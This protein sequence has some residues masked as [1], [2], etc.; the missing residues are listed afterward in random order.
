MKTSR[1]LIGCIIGIAL[2]AR[3]W[4]LDKYPAKGE[5]LDEYFWTF[6]GTSLISEQRPIAWSFFDYTNRRSETISGIEFQ[7]VEPNLD[8]P[9][10]F[11]LLPGFFQTF[12]GREWNN[13]PAIWVMR[14]PMIVLGIVNLGLF[15]VLCKRHMAEKWALVGALFYTVTPSVVMG[16]RLVVADNLLI[17]MMLGFLILA[18]KTESGRV[19]IVALLLSALAILTKIPGA[20]IVIAFCLVDYLKKGNVWK[21]A[22]AGLGIG[23]GVFLLYGA[24]FGLDMLLNLQIQ[25]AG[26][27]AIGFLTFFLLFFLKPE[28]VNTVFPDGWL[29]LG[30][31]SLFYMA[32][33]FKDS[34]LRT[35]AVFGTC[36]IFALCFLAGE[37]TSLFGGA[38]NGGSLY[39]WYKFPLYP[40]IV[41]ALVWFWKMVWQEENRI[42]FIFGALFL[43]TNWRLVV[44][45]ITDL[46]FE[47]GIPGIM[48]RLIF[49]F[50]IVL[51]I[52][53]KRFWKYGVALF[54]SLTVTFSFVGVTTIDQAKISKDAYY[55]LNFQ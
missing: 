25:Q 15:Y 41:F 47:R 38:I 45:N 49:L 30:T 26:G 27:R 29:L 52:I 22:L 55:I 33:R 32:I 4:G 43:L 44:F 23:A 16:S 17:T 9:P 36:Y 54:L 51:A 39:G 24:Y 21:Y 50:L 2:V 40:I 12:L 6:L 53:P 13:P 1:I 48:V 42:A 14:L 37:T 46:S 34:F 7:I 10:F 5:T 11:A 28:V 20:A 31:I 3:L 8:H 19:E 35:I 18:S